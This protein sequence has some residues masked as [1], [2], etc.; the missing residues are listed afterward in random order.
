MLPFVVL[1][2]GKTLFAF[3]KFE[4]KNENSIENYIKTFSAKIVQK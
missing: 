3:A 2:C 4:G 1:I